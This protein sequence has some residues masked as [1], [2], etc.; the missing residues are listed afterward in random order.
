MR[1]FLDLKGLR[2]GK[3]L[4]IQDAGR[5]KFGRYKWLCKCDCGNTS[6]HQSGNLKNLIVNSCGCNKRKPSPNRINLLGKKYNRLTVIS[7]KRISGKTYCEC[8]C[9]C[10]KVIT[11]WAGHLPNGHTKS[12]GCYHKERVREVNI[13]LLTGVFGPD[14][15]RYDH[16][17]SDE[18]R[19]KSR[20][21]KI[22][23]W[24]KAVIS[25]DKYT[26]QKCGA[27]DKP[28]VAH[29]LQGYSTYK[30]LRTATINGV[31]LCDSC[32][33][34]YHSVFGIKHTQEVDFHFWIG[35]PEYDITPDDL[36]A[37]LVIS[38]DCWNVLKYISRAGK[39]EGNSVLQDLKKAKWYLDSEIEKLENK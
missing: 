38:G 13:A 39:K 9:D 4:V 23:Q 25:N 21:N 17:L 30:D 12:C 3:L 18:D 29:H 27:T 32:H 31:C 34:E 24:S 1:N 33:R 36:K 26:C 35:A 10:G 14:S 19:N 5:D 16:S 37:E 28:L 15:R 20:G 2:F 7:Q 8:I 22:K 11:V 6:I